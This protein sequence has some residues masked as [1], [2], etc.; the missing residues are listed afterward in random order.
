VVYRDEK[1]TSRIIKITLKLFG[2]CAFC[3]ENAAKV[4]YRKRN[5]K[6]RNET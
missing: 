1:L 2:K 5:V 6:L 4:W 3:V